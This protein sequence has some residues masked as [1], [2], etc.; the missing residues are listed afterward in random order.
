MEIIALILSLVASV[1]SLIA[2]LSA[3][4]TNGVAVETREDL[5]R[6]TSAMGQLAHAN[7]QAN[8]SVMQF[9]EDTM[10]RLELL[11]QN[12]AVEFFQPKKGES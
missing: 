3:S 11:E 8:Q 10:R 2:Y 6:L 7:L 5:Q 12:K 4:G 9:F 1:L